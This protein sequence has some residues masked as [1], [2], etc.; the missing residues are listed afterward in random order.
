MLAHAIIPVYGIA[1][2]R[3]TP[4][5]VGTNRACRT[6]GQFRNS[7]F[8]QAEYGRMAT[9]LVKAYGEAVVPPPEFHEWGSPSAHFR[10]NTTFGWDNALAAVALLVGKGDL[11]TAELAELPK[12]DSSSVCADS[13]ILIRCG[14]YGGTQ[15]ARNIWEVRGSH[16]AAAWFSYGGFP[17]MCDPAK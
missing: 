16:S 2:N 11:S 13:L 8:R 9:F 1:W 3:A 4:T 15:F 6:L 7:H 10:F 14:R 17:Y 12:A 5:Y